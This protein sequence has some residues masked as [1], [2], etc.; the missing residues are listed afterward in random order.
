MLVLQNSIFNK[1]KEVAREE[2]C[3][4]DAVNRALG[5]LAKRRSEGKYAPTKRMRL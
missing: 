3:L 1:A 2:S 4:P 5:Y